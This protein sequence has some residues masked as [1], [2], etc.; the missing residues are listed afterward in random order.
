MQPENQY[1]VLFMKNM[2]IDQ[3]QALREHC[4]N[5]EASMTL[6]QGSKSDLDWLSK[7]LNNSSTPIRQPKPD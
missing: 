1:A 2:E 3:I 4:F 6:S 5:Y 7:N